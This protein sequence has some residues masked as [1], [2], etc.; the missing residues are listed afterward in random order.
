MNHDKTLRLKRNRCSQKKCLL[1]PNPEEICRL[2][3]DSISRGP[4][5]ICVS[6]ER[7]LFL[8]NQNNNLV[9]LKNVRVPIS[10]SYVLQN[11]L[12]FDGQK[13]LCQTCKRYLLKEKL[14]PISVSN[15]LFVET[16]PE[17][18]C[19]KPLEASLMAQRKLFAKIVK[20]PR[21]EQLRLKGSVVKV[22]VPVDKVAA[23][24]KKV[25]IMKI[26]KVKYKRRLI[27]KTDVPRDLVRIDKVLEGLRKLPEINTFYKVLELKEFL[28]SAP[29]FSD[30][31]EID[32]PIKLEK[33]LPLQ[34]DTDSSDDDC[35]R[36]GD[37]PRNCF[38]TNA[39]ETV[40]HNYSPID[41]IFSFD[42]NSHVLSIAPGE[43]QTPQVIREENVEY[44]VFPILLT[45]GKFGWHYTR[46]VPL[47][48]SQYFASRLLH[49]SGQFA[50]LPD[51]VFFAQNVVERDRIKNDITTALL[52][53]PSTGKITASKALNVVEN[54]GRRQKYF[55]FM[56]SVP[57]TPAYW[58]TF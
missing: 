25:D 39:I 37:D 8:S 26:V 42:S 15:D 4:E 10:M 3:L 12:S 57:G 2:F 55:R 40:V 17:E 28:L 11:T 30:K 19:V 21:G 7:S 43:N 35:D 13:Y 51:F 46:K 41:E 36:P 1:Q 48:P 31:F 56:A 14:P 38:S 22:P 52:Q 34:V 47:S 53:S 18:L 5:F 50:K 23:A 16:T 33:N 44:K 49:H 27:Y 9:S 29:Y 45:S 20:M 54:L 24:M 58:Q 32:A 6:C